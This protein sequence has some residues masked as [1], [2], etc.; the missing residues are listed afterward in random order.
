ML[1]ALVVLLRSIGLMRRRHRAVALDNLARR[2][3]LAA[4]TCTVT[5]P[6]LRTSDRL[7]WVLLAKGWRERKW[8][9]GCLVRIVT[10]KG[11]EKGS[12]DTFNVVKDTLV[13]DSVI[14][15]VERA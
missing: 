12:E 1:T 5:R 4:L 14:R 8:H 9:G 11:K 7:F 15:L 10:V 13:A 6:Q 3:Q 2:Q